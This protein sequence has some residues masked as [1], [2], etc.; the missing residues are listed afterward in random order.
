MRQASLAAKTAVERQKKALADLGRAILAANGR[1]AVDDATL[2]ELS[3]H[4]ESVGTLWLR[5]QVYLQALNSFDREAARR[6]TAVA[7]AVLAVFVLAFVW[8]LVSRS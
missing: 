1:I 4:D 6:G 2:N 5:Q 8:R 7:V 3:R